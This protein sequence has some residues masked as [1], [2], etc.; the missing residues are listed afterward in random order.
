MLK[1][2]F[3]TAWRA[4]VRGKV[5]SLLN[6]L[7]LATGMAVAL[8]IG[9]WVHDQY[10]WD[11][12]LPGFDHAFQVKL[13]R[14]EKGGT[15]TFSN[16]CMPLWDALKRDVPEVVHIAPALG[17]V[18]NMLSVGDK[19]LSPE[20]LVV[21]SEFLDIFTFPMVAGD[22]HTALNDANAVV[23]TESMARALFGRTDVVNKTL[24][25]DGNT[26]RRVTAVVKDLPDHSS[27][28][29]SYLSVYDPVSSTGYWKTALTNWKQDFCPLYISLQPNV[30]YAQVEPKIREIVKKY[31]PEVYQSAH[32]TIS[33]QPMKDWRLY[34]E[35]QNGIPTGGLIDYIRL[36]SIVG[37]LVLLIACINFINLSTARSEKRAREVGIRKVIGSSRQALI[38]QF[39]AESLLLT[40]VAFVVSLGLVQLLLPAFDALTKTNIRIPWT[41]GLFWLVLMGY[42]FITGLLA[43]SQPAF[44][45]SSF[46]PV[47]VLKGGRVPGGANWPRKVL[48]VL[49]FSCSIALIIGTSVVYEQLQ[50]A[51][52][53][54]RGMDTERL[55]TSDAAYYPYEALKREVLGSG[56]VASMTKSTNGPLNVTVR[57]PIADWPGRQPNEGLT[58]AQNSLDDA[59]YFKTLG[60]PL[61][62]GRNFA[63]NY[64]VDSGDVI[65]NEAAVKRMRLT[66][67][68]GQVIRWT[69]TGAPSQLR[70]IGVAKDALSLSPFIPVEPTIYV[71]H[72]NWCFT[73]TYRLAPH[74]NT[75]AAL[76]T[77]T[78]IFEKIDPRTAYSY[79]FVDEQYAAEFDL[80]SLTG[81]LAALFAVL[82]IF[83]S[84]LGLFG[85]AAY[86]AGQR[87][88]EIGIRKVLGASVGQVVVMLGKEFMVLVVISFLVAAPV[89]YVFLQRWLEGYYYRISIGTDVFVLAGVLAVVVTAVTISFQSVK[90]AR[91]NPIK[92]LRSE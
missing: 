58:V 6:I 90:A 65:L 54:P 68:I 15:Q 56:M 77:L 45:L 32:T 35:Y 39:L 47:K 41:N 57:G 79:R 78:T 29:F 81:K 16:V 22:P 59:D 38:L 51:R 2:F 89:A 19:N 17:P 61:V 21:G 25:I 34:T 82:A 3:K 14:S 67:P 76:S 73:L 46:I 52:Q 86:K 12:Y 27:F 64:A 69:A 44:Y 85:L 11:R 7:G 31:A 8:L 74:V 83:I 71:Y 28:H 63:G 80:E 88:K 37:V 60:T 92:S 72:P 84:C 50:Y 4:V 40:M 87:T 62:A 23:I 10:R 53:R 49:Q 26:P 9:L 70:I 36:F 66:N 30:S 55:I 5:Y 42:V 1:T 33:M 43:G 91:M 24:L 18:S 48:V 20:G 75:A 13:T